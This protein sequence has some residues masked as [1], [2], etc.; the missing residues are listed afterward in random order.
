MPLRVTVSP[1][2]LE[3]DAVELKGRRESQPTLCPLERAT[4][5][6]QARTVTAA[7]ASEPGA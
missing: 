2:T 7:P 1:R 5:E 3:K 6:V 4:A